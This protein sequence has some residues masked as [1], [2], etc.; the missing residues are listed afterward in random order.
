MAVTDN[1]FSSMRDPLNDKP[2]SGKP[3]KEASAEV[4]KKDVG[5]IFV[6]S[7]FKGQGKS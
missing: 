2:V 4:F 3:A 1:N 5:G 7:G 6:N